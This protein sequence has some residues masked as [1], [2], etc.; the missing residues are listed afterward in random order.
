MTKDLPPLPTVGGIAEHLSAPCETVGRIIRQKRIA[1]V[2][3]AGNANVYS[4]AAVEQIRQELA[5]GAV[6]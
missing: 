4:L 5:R 6:S 1:P 2:A 3:R